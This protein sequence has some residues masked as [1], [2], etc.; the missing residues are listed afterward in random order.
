MV[1]A[2]LQ[3][4]RAI[5]VCMVLVQHMPLNVVGLDTGVG[6]FLVQYWD[7]GSGVDLFFCISGFVIARGLLPRLQ[8]CRS[9][10][11]YAAQTLTFFVHRFWR[12][13]PSA[14]LW[15][16]IPITIGLVFNRSGAFHGV[17]ANLAAALSAVF[18]V[19]NF[20]FAR[21]FGFGDGGIIFPYW[22]LSLEEQFYFLL[23]LVTYLCGRRLEAAMA[24]ILSYQFFMPHGMVY[25]TTRP[26]AIALGVLLAIWS[27]EPGAGSMAP[28]LSRVPGF[29]RTIL[30][31]TAVFVLGILK[32]K[33]I[34]PLIPAPYGV[35][36]LVSGFL[37]Y[38]GSLDSGYLMAP[39]AVRSVLD[40]IGTRSFAIYLTHV[41]VYAFVLELYARVR[42]Q[43]SFASVAGKLI[44]VAV[45][46]LGIAVLSD[47]NYRTIE[48]PLR[49][50][51]KAIAFRSTG[52]G[53]R[54]EIGSR[55][56]LSRL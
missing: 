44:F 48:V 50:Y 3:V 14:L 11:A 45:A 40:W 5:A 42:P 28:M 25:V 18:A 17:R 20:R 21:L 37:V 6:H 23:P 33:S 12:L 8:A 39:G 49:R 15:I 26:G 29:V 38:V 55:R 41:P 19:Y 16:V 9:L 36:A 27:A 22:S 54:L 1:I 24:G 13:Q 46:L 7:G 52:K 4:L 34:S 30:L 51:G 31:W 43:G 10:S 56:S 2:E 53:V 35:V 47:W 32:S